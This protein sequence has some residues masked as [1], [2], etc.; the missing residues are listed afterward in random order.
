MVILDTDHLTVIQ[1][2]SQPDFSTRTISAVA[3]L[4]Y[5]MVAFEAE[6]IT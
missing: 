5:A 4:D 3:S 1:R 6:A 2:Q